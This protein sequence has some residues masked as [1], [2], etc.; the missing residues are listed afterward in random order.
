MAFRTTVGCSTT[1]LILE[2]CEKFVTFEP[3][4]VA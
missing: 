2:V 3:S 4:Y 1:E